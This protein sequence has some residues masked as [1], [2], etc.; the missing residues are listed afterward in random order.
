[1]A[2]SRRAFLGGMAAG[3]WAA[4]LPCGRGEDAKSPSAGAAK[5]KAAR[6]L[7]IAVSTYSFWHFKGPRVEV[8]DA[9]ERAA[10]MGFDGVEILHVQMSSESDPY[11]RE[12]KRRAFLNGLDLVG[13]AI[14]QSFVSADADARR[15]NVEHTRKCIELAYKLGVPAIRVNTGRWGSPSTNS[16]RVAAWSRSRRA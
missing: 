2:G 3:A 7:R 11:L 5:P 14:H 13:L 9:I 15:A 4:F 12:L 6:P 10:E 16:W 1:M 8:G